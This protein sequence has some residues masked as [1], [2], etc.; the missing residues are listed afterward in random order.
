MFFKI[1]KNVNKAVLLFSTIPTLGLNNDIVE[2]VIADPEP[3]KISVVTNS[4]FSLF[5]RLYFLLITFISNSKR[6]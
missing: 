2:I 6:F 1:A 5:N 3:T 4:T